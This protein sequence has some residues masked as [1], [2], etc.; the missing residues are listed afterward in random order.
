[1]KLRDKTMRSLFIGVLKT[2]GGTLVNLIV[3]VLS[4]KI[5]AVLLGPSG[6]GLFSLLRQMLS[7]MSSMGSGGQT[8]IVQ[9][10]AN[11]DGLRQKSYIT[12][13]FWLML[14]AAVASV[15]CLSFFAEEISFFIFGSADIRQ[16]QLVQWSATPL[17]LLYI[18]IY[19]KAVLNGFRAI[20]RLAIIET[21]G[22][23]L[24]LV[25]TYPVCVLVA[26]GYALAFVWMLSLAELLMIAASLIILYKGG[27]LPNPLVGVR[28]MVDIESCRYF[29]SIAGVTFFAAILA[30]GTLL[31]VRAMITRDGG[32]Y[33][34]GLFD[35]AWSLSASY[36][37]LL[38]ASFGTYYTPALSQ[39]E[40]AEERAKLVERV[41]KLATYMMIPLI[42]TVIIL[43]PLM[44]VLLYS[45]EYTPAL[46]MVRW[47]LI[48]DYFKVTAW[49]FAIPA[50]VNADMKIY[51]WTEFFWYVSFLFLSSMS[52]LY[53]GSLQGIGAIFIVLNFLLVIY[54]LHYL[55]RVY[56]LKITLNLL[57]PWVAGLVFVVCASVATWNDTSVRW[58]EAIFWVIGSF[59]L[60]IVLLKQHERDYLWLKIKSKLKVGV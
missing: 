58:M 35:M 19:L 8:A 52:V 30:S 9:G 43:K 50:I 24:I 15:L 23:I 27:Y 1:M 11:R 34:A 48:G 56:F 39:A 36:L 40:G 7:L 41:T 31:A 5:M 60:V 3:G 22:P 17:F 12:S 57:L 10:V 18:H 16:V 13:T 29:F 54:Y 25:V 26:G 6:T 59:L 37:M 33:E 45:D 42:V 46:E 44:V 47:M 49:I 32:I 55:R 2:G 53:F 38:L 4:M 21:L 14:S 20:G 28:K 51:F